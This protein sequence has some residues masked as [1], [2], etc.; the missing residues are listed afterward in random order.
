MGMHEHPGADEL[1]ILV[2]RMGY[3]IEIDEI[4]RFVEINPG[5]SRNR[6]RR[7]FAGIAAALEFMREQERT[8]S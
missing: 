8:F 2:E 1:I 5:S 4:R 3:G 7:R 6:K